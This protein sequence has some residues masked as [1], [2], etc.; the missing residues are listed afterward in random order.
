[1]PGHPATFQASS[2]QVGSN[3][4]ALSRASTFLRYAL[5]ASGAAYI[6]VFLVLAFFRIQYPFEL[7]W[8]E[9]GSLDHVRRVLAGEKVYVS[10][11]LEFVTFLYTPLY[12]YVSAAVAKATGVGFLPLRLVSFASTLGSFLIIFLMARSAFSGALASC[13][14]AATF[15][16]SGA[17]FD[18]ARVDSLFLFL[19]LAG[20]YLFRLSTSP[21][22]YVLAG[23]LISLA[24]F[25]KQTAILI[26]L[27][28]MVYSFYLNRRH[29][30]FFAGTIV[31]ILGLCTLLL[32]Y[33]HNGWY[34][35]YTLQIP[36]R[37]DLLEE[38]VV[39][40][41]TKDLMSPLPIACIMSVVYLSGQLLNRTGKAHLFY[42]ALAVGMLG[43]PWLSRMKHGSYHNI[44]MPSYALMSILFGL[45][46]H[47][48]LEQFQ[49]ASANK[50]KLM[51]ISVCLVCMMQFARLIY[52]PL[53]QVPT[54]EDLEAGWKLVHTIAQTE[55]DVYVAEHGY[56]AV[57]AGKHSYAHAIAIGSI[58]RS[59]SEEAEARLIKEIWQAFQEEKFD[60]VILDSTYFLR[61]WLR[62]AD[63]QGYCMSRRPVFDNA[64]VFWPVAGAKFRPEIMLRRCSGKER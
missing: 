35:Y 45:A 42:P 59:S 27:P 47:K 26:C 39:D 32:D 55:G 5:L 18:L 16:I 50:R 7:E 63:Y 17:W 33:M 40:F 22:S 6:A 2:P 48:L 30:V 8:M 52:Y 24:Y 58:L 61:N 60:M 36:R 9:G 46:A 1:M 15:Q 13:L 21:K 10:P 57:L 51:D 37:L 3:G 34:T 14:F 4:I 11:S 43:G 62:E 49:T 41:W 53:T 38:M 20:L 64:S 44:P 28:V 31:A 25:T 56:L 19:L 12:Y 54:R 29:S 23:A